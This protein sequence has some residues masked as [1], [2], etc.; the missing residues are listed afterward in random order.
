MVMRRFEILNVESLWI[1]F[2][3]YQILVNFGL[4]K[5]EL[6]SELPPLSLGSLSGIQ[7]ARVG[8]ALSA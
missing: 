1:P 2:H 8:L 3:N 6:V 4:E 7:N 5:L